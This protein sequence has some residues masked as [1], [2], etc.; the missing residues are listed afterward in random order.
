M[1]SRICAFVSSCRLNC[2]VYVGEL[3]EISLESQ[4]EVLKARLRHFY[5]SLCKREG[6]VSFDLGNGVI[7]K[8]L[9]MTKSKRC[10]G[11][12]IGLFWLG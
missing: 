4:V 11:T 7:Q 2:R 9:G 5:Y 8:T 1:V 10:F 12:L 6:Q 3:R